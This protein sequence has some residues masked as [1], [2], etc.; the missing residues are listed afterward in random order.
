M[1]FDPVNHKN[2]LPAEIHLYKDN[3]EVSQIN[4]KYADE[5]WLVWDISNIYEV[6]NNNFSIA[7]RTTKVDITCYVT[8][9]GSRDL[10]L[11]QDKALLLNITTAGRS[12]TEIR[13]Q[14]SVLQSTVNSNSIIANLNNFNWQN[15]GWKDSEGLDSKG[16]DNGSYLSIAN[17]SNL[18]IR[19]TGSGLPINQS[20]DYTFEFRFRVRNVQEYST[21]IRTIPKYFYMIP[22]PENEGEW[23]ETYT[24]NLVNDE[25]V[26]VAKPGYSSAYESVIKQ[27]GWKIGVDK[28]GN[29]LM[30]EENTV[31]E[32]DTSS[33]VV[34]R[35]LND[36]G[37]GFCIGTQEA[38]F[39]TPSGIANVRYCEDEVINIS[40]VLSKTDNLCYIYLNGV[41]SGTV[42][43]PTGTGSSFTIN[44]PFSFNS[45]YC[46]LDL[47][48]FRIYEIGLTMP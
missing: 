32:A 40:M 5:G 20:K 47:Y 36:N 48:R 33:G 45:D 34:I 15:N 31:K 14:R 28:Y 38:F 16:V 2:G 4:A 22:D 13:S 12:S 29:L 42:A 6:G 46:D 43:M 27:N 19:L 35:W 10:G 11:V 7:C 37:L 25:E 18:D 1:V 21:L 3:V 30:D 41:L 24:I 9:V 8:T 39:R 44:S 26:A 17:G 23:I